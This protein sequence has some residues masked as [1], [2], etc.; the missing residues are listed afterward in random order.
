[1]FPCFYILFFFSLYIFAH[2]VSDLECRHLVI[3]SPRDRFKFFKPSKVYFSSFWTKKRINI[4]FSTLTQFSP[5]SL[6]TSVNMIY[7]PGSMFLLNS[8]FLESI[9]FAY[10]EGFQT[11]FKFSSW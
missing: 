5:H 11:L 6:P 8:Y 1:M 4:E 7:Y 9:Y 10:Y 2:F 3:Y